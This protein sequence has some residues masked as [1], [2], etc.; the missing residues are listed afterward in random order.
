[1][2][3]TVY[4]V[5]C[6]SSFSRSLDIIFM[7]ITMLYLPCSTLFLL[8]LLTVTKALPSSLTPSTATETT[9]FPPI[10]D[11]LGPQCSDPI[12]EGNAVTTFDC[13]QA[14]SIIERGFD[15]GKSYTFTSKYIPIPK[16]KTLPIIGKFGTCKA[17]LEFAPRKVIARFPYGQID[18]V[19]RSLWVA[20]VMAKQKSETAGGGSAYMDK[21]KGPLLLRLYQSSLPDP[22]EEADG[23][24][25]NTTMLISSSSIP[26]NEGIEEQTVD[27]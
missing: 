17:S 22:N 14:I 1:M 19:F 13:D 12:E 11:T 16:A 18:G 4:S 20:C 5:A 9:N 15:A 10:L 3:I 27:K 2:V 21:A 26:S 8:Y 24:I 25:T 6:F 23:V 7:Q